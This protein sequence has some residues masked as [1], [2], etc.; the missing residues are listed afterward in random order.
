[1]YAITATTETLNPR[2]RTTAFETTR[3]TMPRRVTKTRTTQ[4]PTDIEISAWARHARGANGFG[5]VAV[6]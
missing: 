6:D 5:G 1:M 3:T 2:P 4:R